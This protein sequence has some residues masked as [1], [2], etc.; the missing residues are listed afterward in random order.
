MSRVLIPC[1]CG[2]CDKMVWNF[3]DQG[4]PCK[5]VTGHYWYGRH[6][7]PETKNK[8]SLMR[9]DKNYWWKG[10]KV[11]KKALHTYI[12]RRLPKPEFCQICKIKPPYDLSNIS[13]RYLR[14][15]NDWQWICRK[16]H[17]KYHGTGFKSGFIP[18][19]K[20]KSPN[21]ATRQKI[22]LSLTRYFVKAV[23]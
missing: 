18:W 23:R 13:G 6:R 21:E 3:D 17:I 5:Y 16:C 1:A 8:L 20:G 12:R 11:G 15:L 14:D 22:S 10:D 7:S 19:N 2:H 9:D 4:R